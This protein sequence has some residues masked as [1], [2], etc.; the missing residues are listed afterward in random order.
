MPDAAERFIAA[1]T[2]PM[3]DNPE[4]QIAAGN[5]LRESIARADS[6]RA[7]SLEQAA[8][9]LEQK[10]GSSGGWWKIGLYVCA[11]IVSVLALVAFA[12]SFVEFRAIHSLATGTGAGPY[13]RSFLDTRLG[14]HLTPDQRLLLLGDTRKNLRSGRIKALW[15]SDPGNPAYFADYSIVF[16]SDHGS[17]PPTFRKTAQELDPDNAW[18]VAIAAGVTA[19]E[20]I[21]RS[22]K[23]TL[24]PGGAKLLPVKN[25][26]KVD[27]A[28]RIFHEAAQLE[29]FDSYQG[30]LL[31]RRISLLPGRTDVASQ[32]APLAYL[33]GMS[34]LNLRLRSLADAISI[35]ANQLAIA[36]DKEGFR[37]LLEDWDRFVPKY[38]AVQNTNLVDALLAYVFVR[39]PLKALAEAATELGMPEEARRLK[40]LDQRMEERQTAMK[41]RPSAAG[42][43]ISLHSSLLAGMSTPVVA[44]QTMTPVPIT[45]EELEPGRM[46]DHALAGRILSLLGWLVLG[47]ALLAAGL[48][49]F[50]GGMLPRALSAR[51]TGLLRPGDWAWIIGGGILL[52]FAC[53]WIVTEMTPLGAKDWS[54][55]ASM[56]MVP[57]GQS[58]AMIWL[59]VL[60]P[61]LIARQRLGR[62]AGAAGVESRTSFRAWVAVLPGILAIPCFGAVFLAGNASESVL[63]AAGSLLAAIQLYA[64]VIGFRALFSRS[65]QLLRRIAL[66]RIL[67]PAYATG[68]LLLAG[69]T[70][71]YHAAE[72]RWL[73]QDTLMMWTAEKPGI[74]RYEYD[75]TR[76]FQKEFLELLETQGDH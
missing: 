57:S 59:M 5:E 67:L 48:Y 19:Q 26:A 36:G 23:P 66:S 58:A 65:G 7:D 20:G 72:K 34:T 75:V 29:R 40:A 33:A 14:S 69:M 55:K 25:Q 38:A 9:Y 27:A 63:I 6:P 53:H 2:A 51:M 45:P 74:G 52:P 73:A 24:T 15:D 17:L 62:R 31:K 30:A 42:D 47:L 76:Q 68:M 1:A 22:K 46:A 61:L 54:L 43:K 28:I 32:G 39:N 41:T 10:P 37:S 49:R 12:R 4:L 64:L 35:K 18:F 13:D 8:E 44:K 70:F 3:A 21:D 11:G 71:A 56:F 50:R 16:A 60:L